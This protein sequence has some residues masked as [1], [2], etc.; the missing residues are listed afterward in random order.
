VS[1][2]YVIP[3]LRILLPGPSTPDEAKTPR[4]PPTVEPE[5]S[6]ADME[7]HPDPD[8]QNPIPYSSSCAQSTR[9][10]SYYSYFT[11]IPVNRRYPTRGRQQPDWYG[12]WVQLCMTLSG[13]G[14]HNYTE[15][16]FYHYI[17]HFLY[18]HWPCFI[19]VSISL[20]YSHARQTSN[21]STL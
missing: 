9:S 11:P 7:V 10:Y 21:W 3:F 17:I 15:L 2:V 5:A 6:Q 13:E 18:I 19:S 14:C 8:P 12:Q 4:T 1:W 16:T 20:C